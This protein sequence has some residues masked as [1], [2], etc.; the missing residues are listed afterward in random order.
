MPIPTVPASVRS[1]LSSFGAVAVVLTRKGSLL[2][3]SNPTG[4]ERAWWV[5]K[6]D[7]QRLLDEARE[8]GDVEAAAGRLG[9]NLT[10]H[11][12]ALLKTDRA[13]ARLDGLM[14]EAQYNGQLKLFNKTYRAKRLAAVTAGAN[15]MPY[16][17]AQRRLKRALAAAIADGCQGREF[18]F[19]MRRVFDIGTGS[20]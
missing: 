20:P 3:I 16:G 1:Y 15:Y 7:A 12:I 4:F 10:P 19:A 14:R 17:T 9:I 6:Q 11:E 2:A 5:R 13:L 8:R 18:A